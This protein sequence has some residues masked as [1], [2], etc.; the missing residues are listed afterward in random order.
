MFCITEEKRWIK[1]TLIVLLTVFF[2]LC[3]SSYLI[4]GETTLLGSFDKMDNDDVKYLRSAWTLLDTGRFTYRYPDKDTVFIMPG[5]TAVLALFVKIFG[6]YPIL[7][8]KIFQ[9]LLMTFGLYVFFLIARK[10]FNSKAGLIGLVLMILYLPNIYVTNLLMTETIFAVLFMLLFYTAMYAIEKKQMKYYI[11]GGILLGSMVLFRPTILPFPAVIF[12]IWLIKRYKIKEMF[13]FGIPVILIVCAMLTPWWVRNY[14]LFDRFIPLTLASGNP[15]LQGA[16]I[17]YDQSVKATEGIDYHNM[18]KEARPDIDLELFGKDEIVTDAVEREMVRI[19]FREVM[20]KEPGK[21]IK[22]YTVGKTY[23]NFKQPF[24]WK[25]L[26]GFSFRQNIIYHRLLLL[27]GALGFLLYAILYWKQRK[28]YFWMMFIA[29]VYFN[30]SHLP[31]YCFARYVYPVMPFIILY[32]AY[33]L[34]QTVYGAGVLLGKRWKS[35]DL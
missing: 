23:E 7:P 14:I 11:W 32:A 30:V 24:L 21:Y 35:I 29:I 4:Y 13:R 33:L 17:D 15:M 16:F 22:W 28:P 19:R 18:I 2:V 31:F 6:Q 12:C 9:G 27:L 3:I 1:I 34:Y 20:P 26:F 8:F 5:L 10:I 25:E